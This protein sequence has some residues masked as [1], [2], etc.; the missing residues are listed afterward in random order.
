MKSHKER[1]DCNNELAEVATLI[2]LKDTNLQ[3]FSRVSQS[4]LLVVVT[5]TIILA[6]LEVLFQ[7]LIINKGV[8]LFKDLLKAKSEGKFKYLKGKNIWK[9]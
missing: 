1:E 5:K 4:Q 3:V 9:K 2:E 6:D 8:P 7:F